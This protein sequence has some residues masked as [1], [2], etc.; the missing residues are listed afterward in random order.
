MRL[1]VGLTA[2]ALSQAA[3]MMELHASFQF[4]TTVQRHGDADLHE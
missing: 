2:L 3:Y 4:I 1:V